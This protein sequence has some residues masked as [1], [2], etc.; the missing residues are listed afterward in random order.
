MINE[1]GADVNAPGEHLPIVKSLRR[2]RGDN[3]IIE[4]LLRKGADPNKIYRGWNGM[5]QAIENGD[6]EIVKLLSKRAGVDLDVKDELGRSVVD[7]A[8]ERHW[9]EAVDVLRKASIKR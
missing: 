6:L 3:D 7:M 5:M 8:A 4:M 2:Y 1:G 9:D